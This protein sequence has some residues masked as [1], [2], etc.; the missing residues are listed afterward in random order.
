MDTFSFIASGVL[1]YVGL[2][3]FTVGMAWRVWQWSRT[4]RSPVRLA[5]Y[6]K[7][8]TAAGRFGKLMKDTFIAPQSFE[9]TPKLM[10]AAMAFHLAALAGFVGHLR[11]VREFDFL[12]A[13]IGDEGMATFAAWSGGIAGLIMMFAVLYWIGRRTFGP[14]RQLS[15]PEDYLLLALLLGVIVMGNHMRFVGDVHGP[16]YIEWFQSVLRFQPMFPAELAESS[17]R[18]SL[19]WH[20]IF[21]SAFLV[22]FPFSKLTHAIGAFATNLVRSSE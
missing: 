13:L 12:I 14:Y 18:L 21:V 6:P 8:T 17:A 4:P 11:L 15:T 9:M 10:I 1:I 16:V 7:P 19:N 20:M 2:L 3:V 5:L 22:Y